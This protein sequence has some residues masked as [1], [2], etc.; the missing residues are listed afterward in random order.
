MGCCFLRNRDVQGSKLI[1]LPIT[2]RRQAEPIHF[3]RCGR[4]VQASRL[5]GF[6]S[7]VQASQFENTLESV[8][9]RNDFHNFF[10]FAKN[11]V[12]LNFLY[13]IAILIFK[14]FFISKLKTNYR[15]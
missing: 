3:D 2:P 1:L 5:D 7:L 13:K 11:L 4:T 12:R 10:L 8:T 6:I 9:R 15:K 14:Y